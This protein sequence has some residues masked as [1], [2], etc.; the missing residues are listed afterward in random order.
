[1]QEKPKQT[2]LAVDDTPA[3]IDVVKGVLSNDYVVQAAINGKMALHIIKKKKPDLIL[4][5]IMMPGMDGYE[6]CQ[7]IKSDKDLNDIPIIF[8]TAKTEIDDETKGL[9]M[10]AV[11]YI[12]KPISP[13]ILLARIKTHL[14]L[15]LAKD[16][17]LKQNELL[18]EK[19]IK[20]TQQ[21]RL[22]CSDIFL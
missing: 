12:A 22:I 10:G 21:T 1:M 13:P 7:T 9:N 19:V 15:K 8:L 14:E 3:N 2:I 4:L 16:S 11:D 20:R 6:V 18:E 5:D 17:L